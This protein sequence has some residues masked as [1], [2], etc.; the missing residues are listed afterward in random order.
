MVK[1]EDEDELD[2]LLNQLNDNPIT[3][4]EEAKAPAVIDAIEEDEILRR[5]LKEVEDDR[6]LAKKAFDL[7]Y[8]NLA[9]E[10]DKSQGSKEAIMKAIEL[11]ILASKTTVELLKA[12]NSRQKDASSNVGIFINQNKSG[13]DLKNIKDNIED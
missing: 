13:I 2:N 6:E 4:V 12:K 8:P 3:V 5:G 1:M 7:F 10:K 9:L 11:R